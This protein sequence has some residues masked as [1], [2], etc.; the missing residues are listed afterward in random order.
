MVK[1]NDQIQ[2]DIGVDYVKNYLKNRKTKFILY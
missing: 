2:N 1:H